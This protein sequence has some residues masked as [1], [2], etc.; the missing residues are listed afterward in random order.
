MHLLILIVCF[1]ILL[2]MGMPIAFNLI[3][4]G[5]VYMVS[6]GVDIVTVGT[7]MY[8]GMNGFTFLAVPFFVLTGELMFRGGLLDALVDFVNVFFGR[9]KGAIAIVTIIVSLLMGSIVGLAVASA[10]A[11][12]VFLIPMM[13]K[14][15][16]DPPFASATMAAAS[17]LGPVMPPS[18]LMIIYCTA[19]SNTSVRAMF[20]GSV[21]PALLLATSMCIVAHRKSVK[22]NYPS[23]GSATRSEKW[24]ATKKALPA[25]LLPLIIL[26]GIFGGVF[27]ITEASAIAVLYSTIVAFFIY[28]TIRVKDIPDIFLEA[29]STTGLS[30]ILSGAGSVVAWG[31]ANENVLEPIKAAMSTMPPG[32]FLMIVNII[33]LIAGCFMDDYASVVILAPIIAPIAWS[34]GIDPIHIGVVICINLVIGLITPPFGITLYITSPTA[35]VTVESTIKEAIPYVITAIG[36]LLLITYVPAITT[37]LPNLLL[38]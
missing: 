11:L 15:G 26:G 10:A 21:I 29:T 5:A 2:L 36:V 24:A 9:M 33:L 20:M 23:H 25:L 34:L 4:T 37:T 7:K 17:L 14:E 3:I 27:S 31:I 32:V 35:G 19:V 30:L 16:Y 22:R 1:V 8:S 13:K 38:N 12:G 18:V 28:R 6:C